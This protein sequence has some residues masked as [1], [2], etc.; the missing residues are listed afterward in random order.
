MKKYNEM[1]NKQLVS[2]FNEIWKTSNVSRSNINRY[3]KNHYF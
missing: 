1:S 3:I 2:E